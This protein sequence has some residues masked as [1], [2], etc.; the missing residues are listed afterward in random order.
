MEPTIWRSLPSGARA[1][2][3][4]ADELAA[5]LAKLGAEAVAEFEDELERCVGLLETPEFSEAARRL[6]H[7]GTGI[8]IAGT[9]L[10]LLRYAVVAAG[11]ERFEAVV[12]DPE[13]VA[14][15]WNVE[16]GEDLEVVAEAALAIVDADGDG[17]PPVGS[18]GVRVNIGWGVGTGPEAVDQY[19]EAVDLD[20]ELER[21]LRSVLATPELLQV[22]GAIGCDQLRVML[23]YWGPGWDPEGVRVRRSRNELQISV[24]RDAAHLPYVWDLDVLR[25]A[26]AT[27][28]SALVE[29][30]DQAL[31]ARARKPRP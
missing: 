13:R 22:V 23:S 9:A 14:G 15:L 4:D 2:D 30:V 25:S 21:A 27:E 10:E 3:G 26:V 17:G 11:R 29:I 19:Q 1:W 18:P 7:D 8:P 6:A 5:E 24:S 20:D 28:V 12:A 16:I 31:R